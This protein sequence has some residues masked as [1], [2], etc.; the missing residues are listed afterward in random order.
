MILAS[1]HLCVPHRLL[2]EDALYN[3]GSF[4]NDIDLL[5]AFQGSCNLNGVRDRASAN[6][7]LL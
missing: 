3:T 6:W 1:G 7:S 5:N 2:D 4:R